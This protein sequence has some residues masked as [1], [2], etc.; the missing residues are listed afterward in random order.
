M[1]PL[2]VDLSVPLPISGTRPFKFFNYLTKHPKFL[3]ILAD[4]WIQ[5]GSIVDNLRDLCWK[6]KNI[7]PELKTLNRENF[8]QIQERV[9]LANRLLNVVQVQA[10]TDPSPQLFQQER[11]LR[12]KW[13]FLKT[14]EEAYFRQKSRIW[15]K[16]GDLNTSYFHRIWRVRMAVNSIRFFILSN[17]DCISDPTAMGMIA[18]NHFKGLLAPGHF[19]H[20]ISTPNWFTQLLSFS[21]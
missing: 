21:C 1:K 15:L 13:E 9:S 2:V 18:I 5:A 7:K 6:L 20:T 8:S 14:I 3:T 12:L 11:D 17:G 10:L 4:Y 19:R 16:E